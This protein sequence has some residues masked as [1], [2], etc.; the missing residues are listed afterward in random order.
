MADTQFASAT[1]ATLI[2]V[3]L[4]GG[5]FTSQ[6][7][8]DPGMFEL[9]S[10][11]WMWLTIAIITFLGEFASI[12]GV[13]TPNHPSVWIGEVASAAATSGVWMGPIARVSLH[14]NR[15]RRAHPSAN[16]DGGNTA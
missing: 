9:R 2:P 14:G 12:I 7:V 16:G 15:Y 4:I 6:V 5:Y 11:W 1:F 10:F 13:V 3:L 8:R